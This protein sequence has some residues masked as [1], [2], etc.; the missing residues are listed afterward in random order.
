MISRF[1][2]IGNIINIEEPRLSASGIETVLVNVEVEE[3]NFPILLQG[4]LA[5]LV[6]EN[7]LK[8]NDTVYVEGRLKKDKTFST[9]AAKAVCVF[10]ATY[11]N[12]LS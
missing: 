8:T 9:S 3:D 6:K 4:K 7:K 1:T 2:L 5:S 12:V 10:F 11:L